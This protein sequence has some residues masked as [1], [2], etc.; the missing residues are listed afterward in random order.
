MTWFIHRSYWQQDIKK[1]EYVKMILK[2]II[3]VTGTAWIYY[4][5]WV[6]VILLI[7]A[8]V[9]YYIQL[10]DECIKRKEQEFLVQFKELIQTFSSL[11]NTGYSVENAVKES[12][13]EMQVF[14]SDDAA[15]L[16]ELEIMVRQI[17]VQVPVEQAV[18]ELSERTKLSDVEFQV[19]SVIPFGIVLYMT[20]SFPE[21][22]GNLYGNIAGRG[23]MTG[24]LIIYLVAYGLGRKIIEIEV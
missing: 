12:L 8:G 9:W 22:M 18:E 23:V 3:I 24:C 15:I 16:R 7:P 6:A 2:V 17:R 11:L 19:M 10:L 4:R 21:F 5:S 20:V 13:K 1:C 14:Y